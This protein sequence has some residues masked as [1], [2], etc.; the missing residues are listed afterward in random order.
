MCAV[1]RRVHTS[2]ICRHVSHT[3]RVILSFLLVFIILFTIRVNIINFQTAPII[4]IH[5]VLLNHPHICKCYNRCVQASMKRNWVSPGGLLCDKWSPHCNYYK[6]VVIKIL[7]HLDIWKQKLH[8]K[9]NVYWDITYCNT[10]FSPF[11]LYLVTISLQGKSWSILSVFKC[12]QFSA[13]INLTNSF[14]KFSEKHSVPQE[15]M[16]REHNNA[17]K[18]VISHIFLCDQHYLSSDLL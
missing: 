8:C 2:N 17:S 18:H 7:Q 3:C 10:F 15:N 5:A 1:W 4:L 13:H 11:T 6:V 12:K 9:F 16:N 14:V